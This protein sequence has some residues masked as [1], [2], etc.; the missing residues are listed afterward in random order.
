MS[1]PDLPIAEA[2][3][4]LL[5]ALDDR[6][7]A[8]LQA[9]PG[10]GKSTVVPLALL[11]APWLGDRRILM[12][13]PRRI[14]ARSVAGRMAQ[15]LGEAPGETIGYRTRLDVR[16]G[17]RTRIEV[18]TEGILTRMLQA[19]PALERVGLVIFDEFHER[20]LE[21]DLGLALCL[22]VRANLREELRVLVMSATLDAEPVATLL[23]DAAVV[24]AAGRSFP[25]TTHFRERRSRGLTT[26]ALSLD[27]VV[28]AVTTAVTREDGDVLVFLPGRGEIRRTA[29]RLSVSEVAHRCDVQTLHGGLPAAEQDAVLSRGPGARRRVVLATNVAETSLTIAGIRVV[30]D[31]GLE[32][33][34]V[35]DPATGMSRLVTRKISRASADQR[36]GRAGRTAPG[37]CYRLWSQS[38]H[39]AL[40]AK[41]P[42][43]ILIE[44]LAPLALEL[45]AWGVVDPAQL[46]WLDAPP[47]AAYGQARDL[48]TALGALDRGG[49]ITTHGRE[50]VRIG[51]HPR[52]AHMLIH[53][54]RQGELRLAADIAALLG[55]RDLLRSGGG[56]RDVDLRSRLEALHGTGAGAASVD[57]AVRRRVLRSAAMFAQ[58][59][60]SG[61][62]SRPTDPDTAG[63]VLAMAYP[64][65]IAQSRGAGGRY[66]LANGRGAFLTSPQTLSQSDYVVI[67]ELDAA[68]R[69]AR[70]ELA[71]PVQ[72]SALQSL[73]A[74]RIETV[75]RVEW[76]EREGAV[77]SQRES[78]LG[79]LVLERRPL[80]DVDPAAVQQAL[81]D[82]L[83][84]TGL[85]V[86]PWSREARALRDR[87]EFLRRLD[88][89][90]ASDFPS[91]E[92]AVLLAELEHWLAPWT[93]GMR[94][95][96]DLQRLDL[97][98]I[99]LSRLDWPQ[100]QRLDTLAPSH[101]VVPSGSRI[102][103]DYSGDGPLLSARLQELFGMLETPQL[104]A[105]RVPLKIQLLSPA[106]RPV[107][108][109][110]DLAS[111]WNSTYKEV[112]REL[113]GRYPRHHW[114]DDPLTAVATARA[115][116]R[117]R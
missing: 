106:H 94:R 111:F 64:D 29:E 92:D 69:E 33:R 55:E 39:A 20:S 16:V 97:A 38:E 59:V 41:S 102:A 108:L 56:P 51:T 46:A 98:A 17:P 107:Q 71:T 14:A 15:L 72:L 109:T 103:I 21:A 100:R 28:A 68:T 48:L 19:D 25:V 96:A 27:A 99:L 10:A 4:S 80:E 7:A 9:P 105:G 116:P 12:L 115:K 60:T 23:R 52:L 67:A 8:V 22:D 78:R 45:A 53:A 113:A 104:A 31:C 35:F 26:S 18:V 90:F 40:E 36:C 89:A 62:E 79:A 50:M 34:S 3:P 77:V 54:A 88:P 81:F 49:R 84:S 82:G 74:D 5:A 1:L 101:L 47:A 43:D 75:E 91:C 76:D 13:E 73:F 110:R 93:S 58:R 11:D 57:E 44:D 61:S 32:R 86:L 63:A 112:R 117:R 30:V 95:L 65:R 85:G 6:T 37:V 42:P 83:R 2:L 114:P 66:L 87:I 70:I 24:S